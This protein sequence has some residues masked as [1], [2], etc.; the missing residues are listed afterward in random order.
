VQEGTGLGLALTKRFAELHG[1]RPGRGAVG[2]G[3]TFTLMLRSM[4]SR[5]GLD[6]RPAHAT[7]SR[8]S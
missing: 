4:R 8:R 2:R 3:A 5:S 6:H 1:Q 7:R